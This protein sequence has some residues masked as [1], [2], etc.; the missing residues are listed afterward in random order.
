MNKFS[1]WTRKQTEAANFQLLFVSQRETR[2]DDG[3]RRKQSSEEKG[4]RVLKF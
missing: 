1:P 2:S 3:G 4:S